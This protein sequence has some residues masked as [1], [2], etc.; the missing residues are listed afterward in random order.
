MATNTSPTPNPRKFAEK[1]A[2]LKA[3]EAECTAQFDF[4]MRSV[5]DQPSGTTVSLVQ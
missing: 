1:I 4:V 2:L 5:Q 3:K